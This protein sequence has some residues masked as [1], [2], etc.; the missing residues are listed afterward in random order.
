MAHCTSFRKHLTV[1]FL[2][3]CLFYLE[4]AL[5]DDGHAETNVI[6]GTTDYPDHV[7][8]DSLEFPLEFDKKSYENEEVERSEGSTI[9]KYVREEIPDRT[10]D[11]NPDAAFDAGDEIISIDKSSSAFTADP[12]NEEF[13]TL[14]DAIQNGTFTNENITVFNNTFDANTNETSPAEKPAIRWPCNPLSNTSLHDLMTNNDNKSFVIASSVIIINNETTLGNLIAAMNRTKVCGLLLFYSPYCEFCTNL[15]PLYNAVGR[16]Y[17]DILVIA[18]DAQNVMGISAKYGIVGIPTILLFH[19]G[20]AVAKYNR[21][22]TVSDFQAFILQL[23]GVR[24]SIPFNIT[25]A[26]E[27]GPLTSMLKESRDY[28]LIFSICFIVFLLLKILAPFLKNCV[29]KVYTCVSGLFHRE[30]VD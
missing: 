30:K 28:Y 11:L 21:S 13:I 6:D 18:S 7:I 22:R 1:I 5:S 10:K 29:V 23:T 20:K 25:I 16:S 14:L 12:E 24:A 4:C 26:D 19:S 15:A 3:F 8:P 27:V 9:S 17:R 2:C